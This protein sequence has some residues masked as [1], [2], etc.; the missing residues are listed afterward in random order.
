MRSLWS[1]I[2][3]ILVYCFFLLLIIGYTFTVSYYA[4]YSWER[5]VSLLFSPVTSTWVHAWA[6]TVLIVFLYALFF[7]WHLAWWAFEKPWFGKGEN[8]SAIQAFLKDNE[9]IIYELTIVYN[10]IFRFHH[11]GIKTRFARLTLYLG[12]LRAYRRYRKIMVSASSK[13][14]ATETFLESKYAIN[15]PCLSHFKR[16]VMH[17]YCFGGVY[18]VACSGS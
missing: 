13:Q 5:W 15:W 4:H 1:M 3:D 14:H 8:R 17:C 6:M 2:K 9:D 16:V 18:C 11:G 10:F 12:G 7:Y